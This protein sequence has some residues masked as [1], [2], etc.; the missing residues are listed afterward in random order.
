MNIAN[1]VLLLGGVAMFLFGMAFMGD[2]LKKVAGD[3]L[4]LILYKLSGT[5]LKGI[6]LG[7][8]VTAIIQSSSATSV[9]VVGF[10]NAEMMKVKQAISVI[11]GAIIGTS[12]TGWIICLSSINSSA[13]GVISL[14]STESISAVAA[15][16]GILLRMVSKQKRSK[17]LGDIL[18]GFAVLMFGMKTMSSAV[19]G[20]K[21]NPAFISF[22]TNFSNPV[23]GILLGLLITAILQSAS[24]A[25]GILQALSSTGAITFSVVLP[26]ILGIAIGASVPVVISS[27]GSTTD[28]KRTAFSYPL[29]EI[30]RVIIFSIVFYALNA[31]LHFT[32]MNMTMNMVSIALLNTIFRVTTIIILIPFID[33]I[34]KILKKIIKRSDEEIKEYK[35][36]N[37]LEPRFLSYLPIAI[38]QC[39]LSMNSMAAKTKRCVYL[40]KDLLYEYDESK[41]KEIERLEKT[42]DKYEDKIGNYLMQ[43]TGK[44]LNDTQNAAVTEY[45]HMLSDFERI[46]DLGR[47]LSHASKE[48]FEKKL[49]FSEKGGKEIK[50]LADAVCEDVSLAVKGF[51]DSNT[52]AAFACGPLEDTVKAVSELIKEH[53]VERLKNGE[54]KLVHSYVLNDM[55]NAYER[56]AAHSSNVALTTIQ[57]KNYTVANHE[58]E[59][60]IRKEKPEAYKE[61]LDMY[62]AK[63]IDEM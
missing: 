44:E 27:I 14:L 8:G 9:M 23:L 3:K 62:A 52:Q 58:Y 47:N 6:L 35:E 29:I 4:E 40:A 12:V 21:N 31:L 45:L 39:R 55:L 33:Q 61:L 13:G 1:V 28:G 5:P 15:I 49:S 20:L 32:F 10:V 19:S 18:L 53:H 7:T 41:V 50:I 51:E 34:E 36:L 57:I 46:S 54:S 38:E 43:L 63:Y 16:V 26:I 24:A 22:M 37:R 2:G 59:K 48:L 30:L 60:S 25:V 42:V 17:D 56:I 11:M